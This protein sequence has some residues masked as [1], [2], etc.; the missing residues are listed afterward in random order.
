M[1]ATELGRSEALSEE[2]FHPGDSESIHG[3]GKIFSVDIQISYDVPERIS[4]ACCCHKRP[5]LPGLSWKILR[6]SVGSMSASCLCGSGRPM[7]NGQSEPNSTWLSPCRAT[8][9]FSVAA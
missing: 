8:A 1:V 9:S 2:S 6:R 3:G 7:E 4:I 5:S